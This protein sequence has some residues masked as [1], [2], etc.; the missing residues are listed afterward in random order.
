MAWSPFA[1]SLGSNPV[2]QVGHF[3]QAR[4]TFK[5]RRRNWAELKMCLSQHVGAYV[6]RINPSG[7]WVLMLNVCVATVIHR[8]PGCCQHA[9]PAERFVTFGKRSTFIECDVE[10]LHA[11][12]ST[13]EPYIHC[14]PKKEATKLLAITLSNL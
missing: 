14:V 1:P 7:C 3:P 5:S 11:L 12:H 6:S 8:R 9:R 4:C 2:V 13:M 10:A